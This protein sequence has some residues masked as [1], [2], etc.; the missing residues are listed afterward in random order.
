MSLQINT[1]GMVSTCAHRVELEKRTKSNANTC[2]IW[3]RVY[4]DM[5]FHLLLA[6]TWPLMFIERVGDRKGALIYDIQNTIS[7][8]WF[9]VQYQDF[10]F[11]LFFEIVLV[12]ATKIDTSSSFSW[13]IELSFSSGNQ[14]LSEINFRQTEVSRSSFRHIFILCKKSSR[15]SA[16]CAAR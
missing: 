15:D 2:F 10:R 6:K 3:V 9:D 1:G 4:R 8:I 16:A 12:L 11:I 13:I 14:F 7:D 5:G